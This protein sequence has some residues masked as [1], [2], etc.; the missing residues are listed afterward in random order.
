MIILYIFN[1][2][3]QICY[4]I[5]FFVSSFSCQIFLD[6]L[7]NFFRFTLL[8]VMRSYFLP[9][10]QFMVLRDQLEYII[11]NIVKCNDRKLE[12]PMLRPLQYQIFKREIWLIFWQIKG[13]IFSKP[14]IQRELLLVSTEAWNVGQLDYLPGYFH[15]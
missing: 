6:F 14:R 4:S 7:P 11:W 9:I 10:L 5:F 15:I 13:K 12:M 3:F 1:L 8:F 2:F